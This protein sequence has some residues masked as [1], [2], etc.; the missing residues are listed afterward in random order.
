MRR[1]ARRGGA[2]VVLPNFLLGLIITPKE[3]K[4]KNYRGN[5]TRRQMGTY[6]KKIYQENIDNEVLVANKDGWGSWD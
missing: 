4:L 6:S 1:V 3:D 2:F 5:L